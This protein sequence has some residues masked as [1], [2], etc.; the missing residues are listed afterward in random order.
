M[1]LKIGNLDVPGLRG[2]VHLTFRN[3]GAASTF[4]SELPMPSHA[5]Q[6]PNNATSCDFIISHVEL[7]ISDSEHT[8]PY[9]TL[10]KYLTYIYCGDRINV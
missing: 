9:C 8:H 3:T 1:I 6:P 4:S 10:N 2:L 5:W 7:V